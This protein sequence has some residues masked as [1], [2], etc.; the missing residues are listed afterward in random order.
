MSKIYPLKGTL[1]HYAWGGKNFIADLIANPDKEKQIAE[2][3]LGAHKNSPATITTDKGE[4]PLDDF[5]AERPEVHLGDS[6]Y[7]NFGRLPYLFKV[8]D[9]KDMLSIQV[10]PTK[11]QAEEGFQQENQ[12][13]VPVNAPYRNFKDDNHKPEIMVALSEFWLLHGFL[14]EGQ[15]RQR[16]ESIPE[17]SDLI[18]IFVSK[19]YKGLYQTVMEQPQDLCDA[20]LK[21]LIDRIR[22]LYQADK[23]DKSNPDFWAA[24]AMDM[25][26]DQTHIDKGV[27]SIYFFNIV[28]AEIG[29]AVFQDAG[30]PHAYLEGQNIELMANSDNVLRGGLTPKHVDIQALMN[31]VKFEPTFP[32]VMKGELN[33]QGSERTYL[34]PVKDFELSQIKLSKGQQYESLSKTAE[35][36]LC[37][38]GTANITEEDN[39]LTINKGGAVLLTHGATYQISSDTLCH[40]FKASA[41][42]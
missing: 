31:H 32:N 42:D 33:Q 23:L 37:V 5:L 6:V 17:F 20:Q 35:I 26:E 18:P 38:D 4:I 28:K 34:S 3:W 27:Y 1:Q 2:Y 7:R 40:L 16:L 21:P 29:E 22:P 10:H 19:G 12:K 11:K 30:L 36:L 24:R 13:N 15:L 8:L 25:T 14:E 41:P 9:V 39:Q